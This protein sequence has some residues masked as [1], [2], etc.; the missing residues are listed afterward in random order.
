[1]I[2]IATKCEPNGALAAYKKGAGKSNAWSAT[3]TH[4]AQYG[5][6]PADAPP[7]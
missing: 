5:T 7:S 1:M 2:I 4:V 6:H 3:P